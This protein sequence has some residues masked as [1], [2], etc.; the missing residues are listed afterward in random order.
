MENRDE[1]GKHHDGPDEDGHR[2]MPH[3]HDQEAQRRGEEELNDE[4][5]LKQPQ[6]RV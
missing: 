1:R 2:V 4:V 6:I 3:R 5:V